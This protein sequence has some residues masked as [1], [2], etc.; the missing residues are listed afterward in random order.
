MIDFI[1]F[2]GVLFFLRKENIKKRT[3]ALLLFA[4][5]P[6]IILDGP[7]W[8]QVDL[9]Y[10]FMLLT[11]LFLISNPFL[12]GT[13]FS[14]A[15]LAKFQ[16]IVIPPIV[17]IYFLL[18]IFRLKVLKSI[19]YFI[20]GFIIPWELIACFFSLK[21]SFLN[22]LKQAY[23]SAVGLWPEVSSNA[24]N[25]WF[26]LLGISPT[27]KDSQIFFGEITFKQIGLLLFDLAVLYVVVYL[28]VS[29]SLDTIKLL[30]AA[31]AICFFFF[32]L[33]TQMHERYSFP[34]AVFLIIIN[35]Y[36]TK[37]LKNINWNNS[38]F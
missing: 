29:K 15:M 11:I 33:P 20:F 4:F 22:V 31:A 19:M 9:L 12:A 32:M 5:N 21:G 3:I 13:I 17:G 38:I 2:I 34:V 26:Y 37:W 36:D 16:S 8:G 7:I 27:T 6:A 1:V 35:L 23:L 10:S 24:A 14:L 30:K 18:Q 28:C 25:I